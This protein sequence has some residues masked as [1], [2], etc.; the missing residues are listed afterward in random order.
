MA[1]RQR[2]PAH[3][4]SEGDRESAR[5]YVMMPPSLT[6]KLDPSSRR[7]HNA[8]PGCPAG[9]TQMSRYA[10]PGYSAAELTAAVRERGR[11][12]VH[13]LMA[14]EDAGPPR[15]IVDPL[16]GNYAASPSALAAARAR[17]T[18]DGT[19][20]LHPPSSAA[21]E[22]LSSRVK[23]QQRLRGAVTKIGAA[24][25]LANSHP[26]PPPRGRPHPRGRPSPPLTADP[27]RDARS[28]RRNPRGSGHRR[29]RRRRRRAVRRIRRTPEGGL[30]REA[31][32]R[33]PPRAEGAS[34]TTRR[35]PRSG[36]RRRRRARRGS[37]GTVGWTTLIHIHLV[38]PYIHT[39]PPSSTSSSGVA[40]RMPPREAREDGGDH[41]SRG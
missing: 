12:A 21:K 13:W 2:P 7:R 37:G 24:S 15:L 17:R 36:R 11:E 38:H 31:R 4:S 10:S 28:R 5:C 40:R 9:D 29:E 27:H 8:P 22:A 32:P 39:T 35:R 30:R 1:T 41:E 20:E 34:G 6:A 16:S 18:G 25:A 26:R 23:Q 3:G 14:G 19:G 33:S